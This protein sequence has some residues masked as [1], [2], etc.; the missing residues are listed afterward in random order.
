MRDRQCSILHTELCGKLARFTVK[1]HRRTPSRFSNNLTIAPTYTVV[2]S[3][4]QCLHGS[5]FGCETCGIALYAIGLGIAVPHFSFGINSF[6][7]P[8]PEAL[9]RLPNAGYFGN[10]NSSSDDHPSASYS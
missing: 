6:Q 8:R 5:L 7:K 3:R 2:P 4:A 1:M 9:D 10:V